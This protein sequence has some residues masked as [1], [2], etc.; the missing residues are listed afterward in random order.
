MR[1]SFDCVFY[2][3]RDLDRSVQFYTNMLG[4]EFQSRDV[5]ARYLIDG[6]MLEFAPATKDEQLSGSGNARLCLEVADIRAAADAL[7]AK[8]VQAGDVTR[9]DNGRLVRFPDPDGNELVLWQYD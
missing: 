1:L 7:R 6:V 8:G 4:L 2:H 9:V 3:V 5:V